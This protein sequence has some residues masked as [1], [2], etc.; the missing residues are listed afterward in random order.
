ME[1]VRADVSLKR[2]CVLVC[3][4]GQLAEIV[5]DAGCADV[6]LYSLTQ[7]RF[8]IFVAHRNRSASSLVGFFA[9]R[10][11]E[12]DLRNAAHL[13]L[14]GSLGDAVAPMMAKNMFERLVPRVA[15]G[16]VHLHRAIR[17]IAQP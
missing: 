8:K 13:D 6:T 4:T 14:F 11:A 15:A 5:N 7:P 9:M 1:P 10:K 16:S 2:V 17:R 3:A 12:H